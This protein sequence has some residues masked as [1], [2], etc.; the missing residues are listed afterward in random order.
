VL[1]QA[2]LAVMLARGA[3]FAWAVACAYAV[4]RLVV[5]RVRPTLEPVEAHL[6][7]YATWVGLFLIGL[8]LVEISGFQLYGY[9][10]D[11]LGQRTGRWI[12]FHSPLGLP[13][14]VGAPVVLIYDL[15]RANLRHLTARLHQRPDGGTLP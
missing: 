7:A 4:R 9:D 11:D 5:S 2:D 13:L 12:F 14:V 15:T 10:P 3:W 1:D 8:G 6:S